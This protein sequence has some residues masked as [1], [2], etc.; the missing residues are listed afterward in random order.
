M[1]CARCGHGAGD[2]NSFVGCLA[3]VKGE[4]CACRVFAAPDPNQGMLFM[5]GW[6]ERG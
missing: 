2:H 4:A 6:N 3:V 1:K 5:E